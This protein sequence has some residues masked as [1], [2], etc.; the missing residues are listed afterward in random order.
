MDRK[1]KERGLDLEAFLNPK[2]SLSS[3]QT[4]L[5]I[6]WLKKW[7]LVGVWLLIA[8][9]SAVFLAFYDIPKKYAATTYLRFPRVVGAQN[10]LARDVSLGESESVVR[11]FQSRRVMMRTVDEMGLQFQLKTKNVFRTDVLDS[12]RYG[13]ATLPGRYRFDFKDDGRVKVSTRPWGTAS[14]RV[15]ADGP[16]AAA[17]VVAFGDAIIRFKPALLTELRGFRLDFAFLSPDEA[18][19]DLSKRLTVKPLDK[20]PVA[21]NYGVTLEDRDP[22]LVPEVVNSLTRDFLAV[23]QGATRN[24]DAD[25]LARLEKSLAQAKQS[26]AASQARL[27]E[28][29]TR[30]QSRMAAKE[31]NPYALASAQTLKAQLEGSLD[32]LTQSLEGRPLPSASD[33]EKNLWVSEALALLSGQGV[34][35]AEALRSRLT[36]LEKKKMTLA[37]TH[38][39]NHPYIKETDAEMAALFGPASQLAENTRRAYQVRLSQA[40]T[41]IYQ[42][43][44]AGG[45]NMALELEAK[46]LIDERDNLSKSLDNLQ[47][48]YSRAKL[49]SGPDLFQVEVIDPARP[50]LYEP[51]SLRTRLAFS[52][53]AVVLALFPGLFWTLISQILFPRIW[54]KDDVER[55]LKLKVLGSLFHMGAR[56]ARRPPVLS[57]EG[58]PVEDRLLYFGRRPTHSDVEAYRALRVEIENFYQAGDDEP[59][60]LVVTSTQPD[61]GKSLMSANLAIGFARRGKRT[62]L[63]DTDFRH[64]PQDRMFGHASE[65]GL[66]ELLRDGVGPDFTKRMQSLLL[67]TPQPNL[68][69]MPKGGFD[70]SAAEAAYRAPMV[71]F[72]EAA[73]AMFE[74]I[75][76]DTAPVIVTADPLG[77]ARLAKGVL[78]VVRSGVATTREAIRA[79]EPFRDR[80]VPLAAVVNGIHR[81]PTDE[82]YFHK[83]G[84]YYLVP[85]QER[86]RAKPASGTS[87]PAKG[88]KDS[89]GKSGK[90]REEEV[91]S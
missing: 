18:L 38:S 75:I 42:H 33:E 43:L 66:A 32:R 50:P 34:V 30:N 67:P 1:A 31:G 76:V 5:H 72:V 9:P 27:S 3:A 19:L 39:S 15:L 47:G 71:A 84:Y 54:N 14:W 85:A 74:V 87:L 37:S 78:Y 46:R 2:S 82:N 8:V 16:A 83:Y 56:P 29:Y 21:V 44:P 6:L 25:M 40:N 52:G 36:E 80:D 63:V 65:E 48:E 73:K 57:P 59:F 10:S 23:Y 64:G 4:F 26:L 53:L 61:E 45:A 51:P 13:R 90:P 60:C 28:F 89:G 49:S 58:V 86:K 91:L 20:G 55:K 22:F 24:Q 17:G 41:Q 35:R 11:L 77:M 62:L 12:V 69:L 7:M 79:L 68:V 81:S 70:E 88:F